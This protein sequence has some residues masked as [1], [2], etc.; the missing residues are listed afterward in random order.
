MAVTLA[1]KWLAF[2]GNGFAAGA[3]DDFGTDFGA[4][5]FAGA[6]GANDGFCEPRKDAGSIGT[7]SIGTDLGHGF[8]EL[9]WHSP[10]ILLI[11][12]TQIWF[13]FAFAMLA[14]P[15]DDVG[16]NIEF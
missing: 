11:L 15:V 7:E 13:A 8:L 2:E 16:L 4:D 10:S 1:T 5:G 14:M 3:G 6:V 9:G 12:Q